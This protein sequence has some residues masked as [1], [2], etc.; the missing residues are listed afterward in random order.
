MARPMSRRAALPI[1]AFLLALGLLAAPAAHAGAAFDQVLKDYQS[2]GKI[3]TCKHS[4]KTLRDAADQVPPDIEQYAPDFPQA[5]GKAID[6]RA[7]GRCAGKGGAAPP[8]T[9]TPKGGAL[10][11]ASA[12]PPVTTSPKGV[13][14]PITGRPGATPKRARS[15][16]SGS[17]FPLWAVIAGGA[18]LLLAALALVFSRWMG[19]DGRRLAGARHAWGEAAFRAG[20]AWGDFRDW[21]RLGR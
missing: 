7:Q 8:A 4:D 10:P 19:W 2:D 3:D 17:D 6:K 20:G 9:T 13:T 11:P 1:L 14:P 12:P 18:L 16:P 21:V 15:S 5:L